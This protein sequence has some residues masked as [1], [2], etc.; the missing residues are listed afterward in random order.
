MTYA[1]SSRVAISVGG[2][3]ATAG[4][5]YTGAGVGV[6]AP[7]TRGDAMGCGRAGLLGL[8]VNEPGC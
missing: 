7:W 1:L 6:M 8:S 5:T 3:A 4:G 2:T